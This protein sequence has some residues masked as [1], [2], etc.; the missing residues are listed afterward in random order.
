MGGEGSGRPTKEAS[1]VKSMSQPL[2]PIAQNSDSPTGS[3]FLPS[4]AAK[5][6][7]S[8]DFSYNVNIGG[9]LTVTGNTI[10]PYD[11]HIGT[12]NTNMMVVEDVTVGA[13]GTYPMISF[14]STGETE[15][16][17][18]G[19]IADQLIMV[20]VNVTNPSLWFTDSTF[21]K[22]CSC[23]Y[24]VT[25]GQLVY[26]L[27]G[28]TDPKVIFIGGGLGAI[29]GG[30]GGTTE[31]VFKLNYKFMGEGDNNDE[32]LQAFHHRNDAGLLGGDYQAGYIK[33]KQ[34]DKRSTSE[35]CKFSIGGYNAGTSSD[36]LTLDGDTAEFATQDITTSGALRATDYYSGDGTQ[37]ITQ[38]ETGVTDFDIVIKDGLITSFTK[39]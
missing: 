10:L 1:I 9:D 37:G 21:T 4:S 15:G 6:E 31:E 8:K 33:L 18:V 27:T 23:S 24:D 30:T 13:M 29:G 25:S 39:N 17:Y 32:I 11:T 22:Y 28:G 26:L 12:Y 3:F 38:S 16:D 2:H 36:W 20:P 14:R 19:A 5:E 35:D 7:Q 34:L